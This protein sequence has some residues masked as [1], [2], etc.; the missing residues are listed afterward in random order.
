VHAHWE[1]LLRKY[2]NPEL[3]VE[4]LNHRQSTFVS[5][6]YPEIVSAYSQC[7]ASLRRLAWKAIP[8]EKQDRERTILYILQR[9]ATMA[10]EAGYIELGIA[11]F[12]ALIE[13][14]LFRPLNPPPTDEK[15]RDSELERFEE[16]WDSECPRFGEAGAKG[17]KAFDP[18]DIVE[19]P[20]TVDIEAGT[21][22]DEW[23]EREER[24]KMDM[25]A[26]TTDETSQDDPY[27]VIL[28]KDIRPFLY[29]FTT[30]VIRQVPYTF[31][32]FC[33]INIP[34][35][36]M[37]SN[38]SIL[39]DPWLRNQFD[40]RGFWPRP[41][42]VRLISWINGEV[43]EPERLPGIEGPFTFRR[44]VWPLDIDTLFSEQGNWFTRLDDSDFQSV[45]KTFVTTALNQ[46]K[47]VIQDEWIMTIHLAIENSLTPESALKLAKSYL[48]AR[49]T[50][51]LLWNVYALL[52]WRR[53]CHDEA[54][55]VWKTAIEM[56]FSTRAD[57]IV[58]WRTW[59]MAEV[60]ENVSRARTVL[61]LLS[62]DSPK[63]DKGEIWS[64]GG[65]GE[66]KTRKYLQDQYDRNMSFKA[67][68]GVEFF[69]VLIVLHRYF[70]SGLEGA[71]SK[72]DEIRESL[73]SRA[74]AS[75]P[76]HERILLSISRILFQ[77]TRVEGWYRASSLR[78]FWAEAIREFPYNT[79][80]LSLFA[81]NEANARIDGRVRKLCTELEKHPRTN[82]W[83]FSIWTEVSLE[84][85]RISEFTVRP[86]FEKAVGAVYLSHSL[87]YL[88]A[89][90]LILSFSRA[91]PVTRCFCSNAVY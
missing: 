24:S 37:S 66:L 3:I 7:L 59:I 22:I 58:L 43:V 54:R 33:G 76:T 63:F 2:E 10:R 84:R 65:A 6:T 67:W 77:H 25:P 35:P 72:Y 71:L 34:S 83:I 82:T 86:L 8:S 62:A 14:N 49:K 47:P 69:A 90:P 87:G 75:T 44:K 38:D 79:A 42:D 39:T 80:F 91:F 16:F 61:S 74:I 70:S 88:L 46:L 15:S 23:V 13:L 36:E 27:R 19:V 51:T 40:M 85:G 45:N 57:P 1:E 21:S 50:S 31:L 9:F 32:S 68:A 18:D 17:W 12:Q 78:D 26:R 55:K 73:I 64:V 5:F 20:A 48:K 30:D 41:A 11:C 28:F 81:W 29:V 56:T 53:K 89:V 52:L 4:Y 60:E